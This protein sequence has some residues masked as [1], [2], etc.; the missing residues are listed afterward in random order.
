VTIESK[1]DA[2]GIDLLFRLEKSGYLGRTWYGNRGHK[3]PGR[4]RIYE[5]IPLGAAPAE[6][7]A[8]AP[9]AHNV[10]GEPFAISGTTAL[11][12]KIDGRVYLHLQLV[13]DDPKVLREKGATVKVRV[14]F[15]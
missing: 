5:V 6:V 9:E 4:G 12:E 10:K 15:G 13:T 1:E 14:R 11:I 3:N 8:E 2:H 7:V